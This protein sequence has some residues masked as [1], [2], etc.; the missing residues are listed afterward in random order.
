MT[1]L[2][3]GLVDEPGVD[4][5]GIAELQIVFVAD[6]AAGL[7]RQVQRAHSASGLTDAIEGIADGDRIDAAKLKIEARIDRQIVDGRGKG[8]SDAGAGVQRVDGVHHGLILAGGVKTVEEIGGIFGDRSGEIATDG[9]LVVAGLLGDQGVGSVE[10]GSIAVAI[11]ATLKFLRAGFSDDLD[12]PV[13]DAVELG[14]EGILVDA[15][16]KDRG[17]GRN[18]ATREPIDVN[19]AAVGTRG[20]A[21][22]RLQFVLEFG[23]IVGECVKSAALQDRGAGRLIGIDADPVIL[24]GDRNLLL[25]DGDGQRQIQLLHL[26]GGDGNVLDFEGRE[27]LGGGGYGVRAGSKSAKLIATVGAR[28]G[29]KNLVSAD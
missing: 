13:A 18:L 16:F 11:D 8:F 17:F 1:P 23:G 20:R 3:V 27:P 12:T 4:E 26:A 25:L 22:Q 24:P 6:Y 14:G 9:V 15:D 2:E 21:G 29:L 28:L 10:R 7:G 5:D 19:L